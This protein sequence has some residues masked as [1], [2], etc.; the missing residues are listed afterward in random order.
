MSNVM[1]L[2]TSAT[3]RVASVRRVVEPHESRRAVR[4]LTDAEDAA[5]AAFAERLLVEHLDGHR[6]V[7]RRLATAR[8][9]K[10]AGPS[11]SAGVETRSFTS[12]T[13]AAAADDRREASGVGSAAPCTTHA[14][15]R[16]AFGASDL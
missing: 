2:P 5:I 16:A 7:R 9:A 10:S 3:W 15:R 11:H 6:Q 4:T 13:A 12:A 8:S 14:R 1:P